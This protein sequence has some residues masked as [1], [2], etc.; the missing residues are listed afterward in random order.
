[1]R[2]A[3]H[4]IFPGYYTG[5]ALHIHTNV[6]TDRAPQPNGTFK[7]R[8][9]AHAGQFFFDDGV[10]ETINKMWPYSTNAIRAAHG[11]VRN[12]NDGL[13]IFNDSHGPEGTT[14][15]SLGS[16]G[17]AR[18]STRASG[19]HHDGDQCECFVWSCMSMIDH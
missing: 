8:R 4:T 18:S 11:R 19:L 5:R 13:N 14:I 3:S 6:F 1:M 10:S 16:R 17:S 2:G 15:P 7:A 9:L 12:W